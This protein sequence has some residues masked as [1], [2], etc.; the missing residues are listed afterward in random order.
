M[1]Q[2]TNR[3]EYKQQLT[4]DLEKESVAFPN[5]H[6]GGVMYIGIKQTNK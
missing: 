3:K 4:N 2:E 1:N 5:Y 6:V